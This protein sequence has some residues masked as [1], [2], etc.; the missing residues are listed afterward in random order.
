MRIQTPRLEIVPFDMEMASR[1]HQLS[2]D[3]DTRAFVPDEVFETVEAA[4]AAIGYLMA[5]YKSQNGPQAYPVLLDGEY[6]GYVQLVPLDG[7]V[8]ELGYHIGKP[9]TGYGYATEA[10]KAF[11]PT[12]MKQMALKQV[13][14]VCLAANAASIRV[15]EKCG[16]RLMSRGVGDYQGERREICTYEYSLEDE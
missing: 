5:C 6:I 15:L 7:G 4:E 16:F 10:V 1:V 9:Y 11:L 3:E 2:L 8:W 13:R 14:G 12:I